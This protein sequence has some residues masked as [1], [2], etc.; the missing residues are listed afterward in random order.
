MKKEGYL[1]KRSWPGTR[2]VPELDEWILTEITNNLG[3]TAGCW[4]TDILT[5]IVRFNGTIGRGAQI[6]KK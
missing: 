2:T 5:R 1:N 4:L 3:W 6:L